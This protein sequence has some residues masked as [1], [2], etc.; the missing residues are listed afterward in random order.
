MGFGDI[1]KSLKTN[2]KFQTFAKGMATAPSDSSV[3][4]RFQAGGSA[5]AKKKMDDD[6]ETNM[7][8][9]TPDAIKRRK[10]I[11]SALMGSAA[12]YDQSK[13]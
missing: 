12:S 13:M 9:D 6:D 8:S 4:G 7:T 3:M 11:S 2:D 10:A 5:L 1:F